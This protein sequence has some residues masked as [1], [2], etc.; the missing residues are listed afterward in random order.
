MPVKIISDSTCDLS[1]EL[2]ERFGIEITPLTVTLGERSG[3]D[4]AEIVPED[5]YSYVEST[6][7]LPK[8]G[9]VN[10][11]EYMRVFSSWRQRGYDVIHFNISSLFSSSYQNARMAADEVGGVYVVDTRNL[12]TGQGLVVLHA[13]E[14][15]E[16]GC[17]AKEI[18]SS[19][20]K[21]IPRVEASFVIDSIDYLRKG[22]RCSALAAFG[23]NVL[24]IK[25]CIE[26]RDGMMRPSKKYRGGINS[27]I[28][29]YVRDRLSGRDDIEA[30]RIF[31]THTKC[32]PEVVETVNQLIQSYCPGM[33]EICETIAGATV[34]THCGPGTLGVLFIRKETPEKA[35][36]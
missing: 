17:A 10:T 13:A 2:I 31:I 23:S 19:C 4:G 6:G 29:S 24:K 3:K 28:R 25:P 5:I 34:T 30:H 21:L 32:D 26:V 35:L 12:S 16:K 9:A 11:A 33:E 7:A 1:P 8:T 22:G 18:A 15:A 14:M 36:T 27:V 20:M